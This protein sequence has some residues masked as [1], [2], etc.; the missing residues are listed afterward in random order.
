MGKECL[1][2]G[3]T[4]RELRPYGPGGAALCFPCMAAEP[5]REE[6]AGKMFEGHLAIAESQSP[7]GTAM[8]SDGVPPVPIDME[9]LPP[10]LVVVGHSGV[11]HEMMKR[12]GICLECSGDGTLATTDRAVYEPE[13]YPDELERCEHCKGTGKVDYTELA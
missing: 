9:T 8:V 1:Y 3:T 7:T 6:E 10:G 4:D 5:G 12:A 2:C 13:K 11:R